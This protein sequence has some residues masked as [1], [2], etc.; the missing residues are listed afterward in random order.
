[1]PSF[2]AAEPLLELNHMVDELWAGRKSRQN[3]LVIDVF[4]GTQRERRIFFRD[5]PDEAREFPYKLNDVFLE[6][7]LVQD[8]VLAP[9]LASILADLLDGD[10][11]V[12]NSLTFER[13]S[14]QDYHFDTFYM[15]PPVE[16][17]MLATWIAHEDT[18]LEAGPLLYYPGSHKITPYRFT[19][20]RLNAKS[21]EMPQFQAYIDQKLKMH[22]LKPDCFAAKAG[23]VL[24][25]HA[26]LLHAGEKIRDM[27]R[28]RRSLQFRSG[29]FL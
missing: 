3:P 12:C 28:T 7:E 21:E 4:I 18:H 11:L 26:Q 10:P 5:A 24:I 6:R 1:L 9:A 25:W 23:D 14:Q 17:K 19:D 8:V 27:K 22:E 20:G 2:F 15:P 29:P 13:S 16:N